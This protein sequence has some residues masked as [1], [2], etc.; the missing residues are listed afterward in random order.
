MSGCGDNNPGISQPTQHSGPGPTDHLHHVAHGEETTPLIGA[1]YSNNN[2]SSSLPSDRIICQDSPSDYGPV[3][4]PKTIN[5]LAVVDTE[6]IKQ[7]YQSPQNNPFN[8]LEIEGSSQYV[9]VTGSL[10]VE[11]QGTPTPHFLANIDDS[12]A[13]SGVSIYNNSEDAVL[14]YGIRHDS[15]DVVLA[16]CIWP[17]KVT[18]PCAIMPAPGCCGVV[19][20]A[21]GP[22]NFYKIETRVQTSGIEHFNITFALYTLSSNRKKQVL[23]G[24]FYWRTVI[25]NVS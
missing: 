18:R 8:P 19:P 3:A 15:S 1:A 4:P 10:P 12:I 14:V 13:I 20:A 5:L 11:G 9:Y 17:Y 6:F 16:P 2:N 22:V 21:H 25:I 24:Y 7:N 23:Y